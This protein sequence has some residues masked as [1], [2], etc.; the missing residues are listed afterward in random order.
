MPT[1]KE[2]VHRDMRARDGDALQRG[3]RAGTPRT[4]LHAVARRC[5]G[6]VSNDNVYIRVRTRTMVIALL[7]GRATRRD[8][9]PAALSSDASTNIACAGEEEEEGGR[10]RWNGESFYWKFPA[11]YFGISAVFSRIFART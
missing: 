8:A 2:R 7:L 6:G 5:S 11:A 3:W 10:E 4:P 1:A 9:T